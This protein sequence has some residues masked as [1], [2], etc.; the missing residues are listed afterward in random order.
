M[1]IFYQ[2]RSI[3]IGTRKVSDKSGRENQNKIFMFNNFVSENC[4]V[5][6]ITWKNIAQPGRIQ[7]T[8]W[9]MRSACWKPKAK[10]HNQNMYYLLIF[11]AK[12]FART[13]QL[14]MFYLR[15]PT[16]FGIE[17]YLLPYWIFFYDTFLK[18][19]FLQE[20]LS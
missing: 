20:M 19:Q 3:L 13:R 2:I 16:C 15:C 7:M 11:N 9:P 12:M 6:E 14:V 1:Y 8:M 5:Y 4:A 17:C 10:T 18:V